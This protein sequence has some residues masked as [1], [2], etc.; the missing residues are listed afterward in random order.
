MATI[1]GRREEALAK[2][3]LGLQAAGAGVPVDLQALF[4]DVLETFEG[5]DGQKYI[6]KQNPMDMLQQGM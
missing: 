2:Y 1:E 5:T 6:Q 3:Q 4:I